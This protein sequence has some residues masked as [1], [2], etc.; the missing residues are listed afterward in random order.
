MSRVATCDCDE[1]K[2]FLCKMS[3][4]ATCDCDEKSFFFAKCRALPHAIAMKQIFSLQNVALPL[5][6]ATKRGRQQPG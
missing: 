1:K 4:V 3:R 6:N 2:F 5:A